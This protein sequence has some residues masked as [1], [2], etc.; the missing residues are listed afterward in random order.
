MAES[1]QFYLRKMSEQQAELQRLTEE[2][3][4]LRKIQAEL[5]NLHDQ[6]NL[7]P[8]VPYRVGTVLILGDC[9]TGWVPY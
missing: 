3:D 2:R 5:T 7:L 9:L 8:K 4:K 1:E 6:R